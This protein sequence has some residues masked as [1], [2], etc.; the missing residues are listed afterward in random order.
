MSLED[1]VVLSEPTPGHRPLPHLLSQALAFNATHPQ[2]PSMGAGLA[3]YLRDAARLG[4]TPP[5]PLGVATPN[6]L[7]VQ[8]YRNLKAG[9][10]AHL[11]PDPLDQLPY[12]KPG[13][14]LRPEAQPLGQE[15]RR[16]HGAHGAIGVLTGNQGEIRVKCSVVNSL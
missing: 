2:D 16:R 12:G 3:E 14:L 6:L 8:Y 13:E 15:V 1:M 10:G 7:G 5:V 11:R 4:G 9:R